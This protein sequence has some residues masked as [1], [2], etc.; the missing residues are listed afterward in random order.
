M[1]DT[2]LKLRAG[3]CVTVAAHAYGLRGA[4]AVGMKT[5]YL[6]RWTDDVREDQEFIKRENDAYVEGMRELDETISKL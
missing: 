2:V 3:E 6:R 5:V 4:K 1:S